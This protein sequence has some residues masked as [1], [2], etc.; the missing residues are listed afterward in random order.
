MSPSFKSYSRTNKLAPFSRRRSGPTYSQLVAM[1]GWAAHSNRR[2]RRSAAVRLTVKTVG[3]RLFVCPSVRLVGVLMRT[4]SRSSS[5][6]SQCRLG[7]LPTP[8]QI[9]DEGFGYG[10][11]IPAET[12]IVPVNEQHLYS[13]FLTPT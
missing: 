6:A 5:Q 2:R 7:L 13:S 3:I 10:P 12:Q 4:A 8:T 11:H 9:S 1:V